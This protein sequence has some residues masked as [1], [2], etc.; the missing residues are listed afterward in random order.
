MKVAASIT[1][2]HRPGT[3][4]AFVFKLGVRLNQCLFGNILGE[5]NFFIR[6][7]P[8]H[9]RVFAVILRTKRTP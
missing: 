1:P 6:Y 2:V 8:Y 9:F 7:A 5:V 4:S 3:T